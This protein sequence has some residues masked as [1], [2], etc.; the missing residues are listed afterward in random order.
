[1]GQVAFMNNPL[2]GALVLVATFVQNEAIAI[3]GLIGV[4][5]CGILVEMLG[6]DQSLFQNGLMGF[7]GHLVGLALATFSSP[8]LWDDGSM[9]FPTV[10]F[11]GFSVILFQAIAR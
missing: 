3:Y 8:K 9:I 6:L 1:M 7:N 4:V 2:T 5:T 11:S 10:M